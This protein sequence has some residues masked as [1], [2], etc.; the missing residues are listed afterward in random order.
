[1]TET[2]VFESLGARIAREQDA[3]LA[4]ENLGP[5][6]ERLV[7]SAG[8]TRTRAKGRARRVAYVAGSLAAA[9]A[10]VVSVGALIPRGPEPLEVSINGETL[11]SAVLSNWLSAPSNAALPIQFSDGTQVD[12]KAKS[13]ARV[14]RV[15][16]HGAHVV[17]ESGDA[18][19]D[20]VPTGNANWQ[21]SAGPFLVNVV[22]TSFDIAWS[23][24]DDV[25]TLELHEGK[26]DLSG[27]LFGAGRSLVAGETVRAS[28]LTKEYEIKTRASKETTPSELTPPTSKADTPDGSS[29]R[30]AEEASRPK[31][32]AAGWPNLARSGKYSEAVALATET[33]FDKVLGQASAVDLA[34]LG[35]AARFSGDSGK[36]SSA[37]SALRSRFPGG[38]HAA[39]AAYALAR[40]HFDQRG[41][42]NEAARWFRTYLS[43]RPGGSLAR[44]A[45][46]RLLE[47]LRRSGNPSAAE[48]QARLYLEQYPD[49][50]HA[51][52]ARSVTS[53]NMR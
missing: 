48:R 9:A 23:P 51:E 2:D 47:C 40:L 27:C 11:E 4:S 17:L 19:L 38:E 7:S 41:A 25:F 32:Q 34:L 46:G 3:Q 26:V 18:H 21:V 36:A 20:V 1:M 37:Y 50:P 42:F 22:G 43:E 14:L 44:E 8:S 31:P 5:V 29:E 15:G 49:G 30:A 24:D 52:L 13:R 33:G 45:Q 16:E 35:D 39:N 10:V 28:C 53:K 6:R 12:L